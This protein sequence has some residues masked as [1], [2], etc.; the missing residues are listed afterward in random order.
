MIT[1][2]V[3]TFSLFDVDSFDDEKDFNSENFRTLNLRSSFSNH[4]GVHLW[5]VKI[6]ISEWHQRVFFLDNH[7]EALNLL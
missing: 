1:L 5:A 4:D 6:K 2:P 7:E 3:C